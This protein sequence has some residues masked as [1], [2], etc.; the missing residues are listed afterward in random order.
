MLVF[1]RGGSKWHYTLIDISYAAIYPTSH[2]QGKTY[3]AARI[4]SVDMHHGFVGKLAFDGV[5]DAKLERTLKS[6]FM[7]N[8][9]VDAPFAI[10]HL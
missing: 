9:P 3:L 7:Y 1:P 2:T 5:Y 4:M 10:G 6:E 8:G